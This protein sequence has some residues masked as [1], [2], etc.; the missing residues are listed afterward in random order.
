MYKRQGLNPV[1]KDA[2]RVSHYEGLKDSL[3]CEGIDFPMRLSQIPK[4]ERMNQISVNVFAFEDKTLFP[5]LIT[6]ETYDRH[7]NLLLLRK[8]TTDNAEV[9]HY[10]LIKDLGR[11]LHDQTNH[12][13]KIYPC[14]YCLHRFS[15][16]ELLENH[17]PYC[18][19]H[20][21]QRVEMPAEKDKWLKFNNHH[22][23]MKC[24]FVIY[25]DFESFL[26]KKVIE[27][28]DEELIELLEDL[29]NGVRTKKVDICYFV[30]LDFF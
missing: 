16:K 1:G 4:F 12:K 19:I 3:N 28:E 18:Q 29:E 23:Q 22:K 6:K 20:G 15:R 5:L 17:R 10:V 30:Q 2:Q 26:E 25:A 21:A 27:D 13:M 24:P 14:D 9:T 7:V 11:L 8:L